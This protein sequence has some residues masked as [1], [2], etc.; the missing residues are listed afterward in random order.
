MLI[1]PLLVGVA[2]AETIII[3]T[4]KCESGFWTEP[5]RDLPANWQ[6]VHDHPDTSAD[7]WFVTYASLS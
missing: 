5:A 6:Y 3:E 1:L 4:E 2:S 7:G